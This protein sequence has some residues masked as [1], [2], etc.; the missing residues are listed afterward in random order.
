MTT[1]HEN[2]LNTKKKFEGEKTHDDDNKKKKL[3]KSIKNEIS[4]SPSGASHLMAIN[5][6]F[7]VI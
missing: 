7:I 3:R 1:P 6:L 4:V 2:E 5:S